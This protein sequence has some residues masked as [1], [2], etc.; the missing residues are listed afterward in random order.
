VLVERSN[1]HQEKV[2]RER[3]ANQSP[4]PTI[5]TPGDYVL[6]DVS[7]TKEHKLLPKWAGP[8]QVRRLMGTNTYE[9]VDPIDNHVAKYPASR[10]KKF[11]ASRCADIVAERANDKAE[12]VLEF[13]VGHR[14]EPPLPPRVKVG[15]YCYRSNLQFL[16]R[17]KG[18]AAS[19]D[20][21]ISF[22]HAARLT[23]LD[24]YSQQHPELRL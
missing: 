19:D 4:S 7:R 10:L 12:F 20:S 17:W 24:A 5:Y 16:V 23:A 15:Q 11:N 2:V 3:L 1:A 22:Y 18:Y 8:F 9:I 13:I 21:Y 6:V 14:Y